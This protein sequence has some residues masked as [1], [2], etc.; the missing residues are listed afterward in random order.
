[1]QATRLHVGLCKTIPY[2]RQSFMQAPDMQATAMLS[3]SL[4]QKTPFS[5][6]R[7][8]VRYLAVISGLNFH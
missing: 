8:S 3:Q 1:M 7:R 4:N 6:L 2:A 5:V